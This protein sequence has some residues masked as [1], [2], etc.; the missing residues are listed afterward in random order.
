ME[1]DKVMKVFL[2]S[3]KEWCI[4]DPNPI[5]S[6]YVNDLISKA[7]AGD[8]NNADIT[9]V[10]DA[11]MKELSSMFPSTDDVTKRI[12]FGTAGLRSSMTPGPFGMNDLTVI[13]TAQGLA[14]Y[15]LSLHK[16]ANVTANG[17]D[18]D[19]DD[20]SEAVDCK[21]DDETATPSAA[22]KQKTHEEDSKPSSSQRRLRAVVGY[23]HRANNK[24]DISSSKFAVLTKLVFEHVGIDC[25]VLNGYIF[26]PLV[27]Y[28]V[29]KFGTVGFIGIMITA[30]HNPKLDAGYKVYDGTDSCQ[31]RSPTDQHI[32][33]YILDN[34]VPWKNYYT[35]IEK[36][37]SSSEAPT[38]GETLA[39]ATANEED[40]TAA[41]AADLCRTL[42]LTDP[43]TTQEMLSSYYDSIVNV[44]GLRIP[45]TGSAKEKLPKIAYTAMHGVGY[46]YAKRIFEEFQLQPFLSVQEQQDPDP[47]FPTVYFRKL[48][49]CLFVRPCKTNK[50]HF[51]TNSSLLDDGLSNDLTKYCIANPEEKGALEIAKTFATKNDCNIILANDP[52]ADRLAVAERN[53]TSNE[54]IVFHGD[55]IGAML[56][57]WIWEQVGSKITDKVCTRKVD[58]LF[59]SAHPSLCH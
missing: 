32:S 41:S 25:I 15:C 52:D 40:S 5:T 58:D 24:F 38:A 16:N 33:K 21:D 55:Q 29:Q 36:L 28:T 19:H 37:K 1:D 35:D 42:G 11:A 43:K 18:G 50:I 14:K 49:V 9:D 4:N 8:D 30:S 59:C 13:Q 47:N 22:K 7:E 23:D 51:C 20:E 26:T 3:A 44:S 12:S 34:L 6:K 56:G 48:L 10:A 31:I 39:S 45:E 46:P 17:K 57:L 53:P 2:D 27:P 54:W